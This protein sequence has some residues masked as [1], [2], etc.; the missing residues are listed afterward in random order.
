[1]HGK[2]F[3]FFQFSNQK[4]SSEA[5]RFRPSKFHSDVLKVVTLGQQKCVDL[6]CFSYFLLYPIVELPSAAEHGGQKSTYHTAIEVTKC[7]SG[8]VILAAHHVTLLPWRVEHQLR[9]TWTP[10]G[11]WPIRC[12]RWF[13]RP[14]S[15]TERHAVMKKRIPMLYTSSLLL[16]RKSG[17]EVGPAPTGAGRWISG[18]GQA[19]AYNR[20]APRPRL[21]GVLP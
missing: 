1:M 2:L 12:Y 13:L 6:N 7:N 3:F 21:L 5:P 16:L 18:R 8:H 17:P 14:R 11:T 19:C 9:Q 10:E 4:V 15:R 20:T